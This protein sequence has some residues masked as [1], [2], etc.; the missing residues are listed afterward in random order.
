MKGIETW[1]SIYPTGIQ[2]E[3]SSL[4]DSYTISALFYYPIK[5]LVYCGALRYISDNI[6][7]RFRTFEPLDSEIAQTEENNRNPPLFVVFLKGIDPTTKEKIIECSI[8]VIGK[9]T[10]AMRLVESSQQAF[11]M[12]KI[13]TD[14]FY[15]KYGNIPAVF[16]SKD[17]IKSDHKTNRVIVKKFDQSGYFYAT[18]STSIDLWQLVDDIYTQPHHSRPP[19]HNAQLQNYITNG[20]QEHKQQAHMKPLDPYEPTENLIS[21]E[22]HIDP[23]TG[24]NIYVRYLNENGNDLNQTN[25]LMYDVPDMYYSDEKLDYNALIEQQQQ[26][27]QQILVRQE[28][29]PSPIIVEKYIK[30][31]APQV[32]IKEIHVQEPAPPPIKLV[33]KVENTAQIPLYSQKVKQQPPVDQYQK[34]ISKQPTYYKQPT[35]TPTTLQSPRKQ[36]YNRV[37]QVYSAAPPAQHI[38]QQQ[39]VQPPAPKMKPQTANPYTSYGRFGPQHSAVQHGYSTYQQNL[40][41][42]KFNSVNHNHVNHPSSLNNNSS[43]PKYSTVNI[44]SSSINNNNNNNS[45]NNNNINNNNSD[46]MNVSYLQES[47][48]Q[49]P[50]KMTSAPKPKH[51]QQQ[52]QPQ[53][54][55]Q[56]R[57]PE[58]RN[59]YDLIENVESLIEKSKN[60]QSNTSSMNNSK[61]RKIYVIHQNETK[62]KS[63]DK[64]YNRKIIVID[65]PRLS[66]T[67]LSEKKQPPPPQH[68]SMKKKSNDLNENEISYFSI[69]KR[70]PIKRGD[71]PSYYSHR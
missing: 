13:S 18:K 54:Q 29:T 31:K 1:L 11:N 30:K 53:V 25:K 14:A 33:Q 56:Q 42:N 49:S 22:K 20:E 45:N 58:L 24:Q 64:K 69:D 50:N 10:T 26:Q 27:Q 59:T 32:I 5:S 63:N 23:V 44:Q 21:V 9:K 4:S 39:S 35:I 67:D 28:K 3:H 38:Q 70:Q 17:E 36:L 12:S 16:C 41:P 61:G 40:N 65:E 46:N 52:Q 71:K 57:S 60:E 8:F 68:H 6:N 43:K 2:M 7:N 34:K 66:D 55:P 19:A 37:G 51:Q 47:S 48:Y 15:A 62:H